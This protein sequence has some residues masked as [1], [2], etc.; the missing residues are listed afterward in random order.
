MK[1]LIIILFT[2]LLVACKN[3]QSVELIQND[4]TKIDSIEVLY[5]NTTEMERI[6]PLGC[7]EIVYKGGVKPVKFTS[8]GIEVPRESVVLDT[9]I[10]NKKVLQE[11]EIELSKMKKSNW[12]NMDARTK[13]YIHF[14]NG[15]IDSLC[16]DYSPTLACYN[17]QSVELTNKFVY[18]LRENCG[19]YKWI[20]I[21]RGLE[22]CDELN[23]KTFKR[24]KVESIT[25]EKY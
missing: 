23:D 1:H 11:I 15:T 7:D 16:L 20:G 10:M 24:E 4:I 12:D 14:K 6:N 17:G 13:C 22:Y 2:F 9:T 8:E 25:G 19:F 18:L 3:K 21:S 5:Y